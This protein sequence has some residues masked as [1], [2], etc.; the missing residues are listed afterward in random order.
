[1]VAP[2]DFFESL[3][4]WTIY[5]LFA[6]LP[7]FFIPLPWVTLPQS[8]V[9]IILA[10]LSIAIISWVISSLMGGGMRIPRTSILLTALLLP[11]AYGASIF[12]SSGTTYSIWGSGVEQDTLAAV[13]LWYIALL[14]FAMMFS[15]TLIKGIYAI[16][17]LLIGG[18]AL[19]VLEFVHIFFPSL[20]S[21]GGVLVSQTANAL[22]GWYES[23]IFSGLLLFL[24]VTTMRTPLANRAWRFVVAAVAVLSFLLLVIINVRDVWISLAAVSTFYILLDFVTGR[25]WYDLFRFRIWRR[26]LGLI[27]LVVLSLI[28]VFAGPA[29]NTHLPASMQ[30][31]VSE[32][33]PSWSG[34]FQIGS[35]ALS[36]PA[37]LVFGAG[38]NTFMR[39]W[40]LYKPVEINQTAFWNADF[41][42]GIGLIPTSLI[43]IGLVGGFAWLL[44]IISILWVGLRLAHSSPRQGASMLIE[45][46]FLAVAYL[47]A[48]HVFYAPGPALSILTF[49]L[50]GVAIG[51]AASL[52]RIP[53]IFFATRGR[54]GISI[55]YIITLV[56]FVIVAFIVCGSIAR[57]IAAEVLINRSIT[58]FNTAGDLVRSS[59]YVSQ[60]LKIYPQDA[61][62]Q[63]TAVEIGLIQIQQITAATSSER[64]AD[65]LKKIVEDTIRYALNAVSI[66]GDD[67]QN[68]LE[69]ANL[70]Q[71]LAG[72]N[73][74]GAYE[75]AKEAY[76]KLIAD[77]PTNPIAYFKRAQLELLE[78]NT[79]A[80]IADL[81][82]AVKLKPD[83]AA[84]YYLASQIYASQGNFKDAMAPAYSAT[85]AASNDPLAWYNLAA[86]AYSAGDYADATPSAEQAIVLEPQYAN[87]LYILGLS[88][89]RLGRVDDSKRIF[90]QLDK[91]NP[92]QPVVR[93]IITNLDAGMSPF[94]E[95]ASST[96]KASSDL[97]AHSDK[98][99]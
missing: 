53:H 28:F 72:A 48:F 19:F 81:L 15:D 39:E 6:F 77:N 8:K 33:R 47:V 70:Y 98:K 65:Q 34:T 45:P 23:G 3:A 79:D 51:Y 10:L 61:R 95:S 22:G 75:N 14:G 90:G 42:T 36:Q 86:I 44:F 89:Y 52:G 49:L 43:T 93:E 40:S 9:L 73:V 68:W 63:R 85:Q 16:R 57:V 80:A 78:K 41:M 94:T 96:K 18:L 2:K 56:A 11:F 26:Y 67:Y 7:I 88:Y 17:A 69:L 5:L 20:T 30:I 74:S 87:A 4:S 97:S 13:C 92:G 29:I 1:M 55:S 24:S 84:G 32:A 59:G 50:L 38:P 35:R 54:A 12:V 82:T 60:A 83:F 62:G 27:A 76:A 31:S 58:T 99:K 46:L 91:L 71:E 21:F 64:S 25:H 66:N 37:Q